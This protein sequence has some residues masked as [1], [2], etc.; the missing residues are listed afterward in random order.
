M[1]TL[2][3]FPTQHLHRSRYLQAIAVDNNDVDNE[4]MTTIEINHS[5]Y[6]THRAHMLPIIEKYLNMLAQQDIKL[7]LPLYPKSIN[8]DQDDDAF[9]RICHMNRTKLD[10]WPKLFQSLDCQQLHDLIELANYLDLP[11]LMHNAA[12]CLKLKAI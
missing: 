5:E 8:N 3:K 6:I 11:I 12:C 1:T 7:P 4:N 9:T 10:E 2:W